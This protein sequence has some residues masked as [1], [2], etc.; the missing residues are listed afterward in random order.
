M[1]DDAGGKSLSGLASRVLSQDADLAFG[2]EAVKAPGAF[3]VRGFDGIEEIFEGYEIAVD[4]VSD[5]S[6][7]DLH[8]LLD[9]EA[10]LGIYHKYD[11]PRF[12]HGVIA[13]IEKGEAGFARCFYR[14]VLKPAL[15]RLHYHSDSRIFQNQS[16]VEISKTILQKN[17]ITDIDWRIAFDHQPREYCVQYGETSFDFLRRIWAEEGLF[18]FFEHSDTN[19]RMIVSDSPLSMPVLTAAPGLTFNATPGGMG[20]GFWVSRFRQVERLRA[21]RRI[22][23]DYS[24]KNPPYNQQHSVG[25]YMPNGA[26][27]EYELY[28]YPGRHKDP[29]AGQPFNDHALEAHR[30]EATTAT[31]ETNNIQLSAGFIFALSDHPDAAANADHR[32]L[33]VHH[34][35]HQPAALQEEAPADS[36]TTYSARFTSQPA[37]LPYRP[38]NP[39]P[40]PTVEGPQIAHVTGPEGEE[41]YCDE[42]G[43]IRIWFPWDRHG[44]K[45]ETSS[46]WVRVSQNWAGGTWGHMAIPRIGQEVVVD[47]LGGDPDQPIVTGRTYH[48]TNRPPYQLPEHKTKMVIRSNS[49][50]GSGFN[51]ISFEDE[52]GRENI[53]LHAQKDQ[54][55]KILNNR[56]KRVDNDQI[57]SVGSNKS[58]E[59][60]NNHQ[61]RIGGSMNLTVGGGGSGAGLFGVLGAI[62]AAGGQDALAGSE[63]VGN[64]LI[65]TFVGTLATAGAAAEVTTLAG[66]AGFNAA[67]QNHK[68][69]GA[70]QSAAG[71]SLGALLS[72]AMPMSGIKTTM[73]EKLVSD[74]IGL[75]RTEQIGAYKN[76]SVGH[77]M[78]LHIGKEFIINVGKSKL[79]M[80]SEGNITLIGTKFNFSASGHVQ[81]NG[82]VID[83]N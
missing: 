65:S 3:V 27:G 45:D 60:G 76:T 58:V 16:V 29:G 78:T 39:N 64:P 54:T 61:E 69:A 72:S 42:H 5:R 10:A 67:G 31:G 9:S 33:R 41:I 20:R 43:R 48:A 2:F 23:R 12:L 59:V 6:D 13:E 35:G 37:R 53:A 55:L 83:L 75:A 50:K 68:I 79:V 4:L 77:T 74:T 80:D 22:S 34:Q 26:R 19:H 56:M 28:H 40:K 44:K 63:T 30:V 81:I 11:A 47:F 46:C 17:R 8:A 66:K 57:E 7:L 70:G 14:V 21:T 71:S 25:Q 36:A 24:F 15:H 32:L 49:H 52:T 1:M 62:A 18:F 51:E 82:K 38:V 73:V